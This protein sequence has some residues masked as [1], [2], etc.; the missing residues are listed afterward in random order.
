M[1]PIPLLVLILAAGPSSAADSASLLFMGFSADGAHF[2]WEQYGIQDGSGF[3]WSTI[4]IQS[5]EDGSVAGRFAVVMEDESRGLRDARLECL[6]EASEALAGLSAGGWS[7]GRLLVHHPPTDM[8]HS[9]GSVTFCTTFYSPSYYLGDYTLE[10]VTEEIPGTEMEEYWGFPP[11]SLSVVFTDNRTGS[12]RTVRDA[13]EPMDRDGWVFGFGIEDVR[14]MGDSI[15][16]AAVRCV[17]IG[18]EG[19]DLRYLMTGWTI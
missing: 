11:L 18:F 14:C 16:A 7:E 6:R 19:P 4:T 2:A 12:A 13:S 15:F 8:T 3:P 10:L 1:R 17:S 5:A 9:G